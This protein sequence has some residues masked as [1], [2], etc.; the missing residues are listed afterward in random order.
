[1]KVW[2]EQRFPENQE[3]KVVIKFYNH[4][5]KNLYWILLSMEMTKQL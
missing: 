4:S 1:M 2:V 3:N 5:M